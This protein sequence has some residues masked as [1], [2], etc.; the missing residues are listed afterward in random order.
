MDL[1]TGIIAMTKRGA[2]R[3][4][5]TLVA[6]QYTIALTT[7]RVL[8]GNELGDCQHLARKTTLRWVGGN[9]VN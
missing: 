5:S 8:I 9:M 3:T 6:E 1:I 7:V 4:D 2:K